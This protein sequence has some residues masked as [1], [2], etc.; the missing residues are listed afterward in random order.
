MTR[1]ELHGQNTG[2]TLSMDNLIMWALRFWVVLAFLK[3]IIRGFKNV[4]LVHF[5]GE[6]RSHQIETSMIILVILF[7]FWLLVGTSSV[8]ASIPFLLLTGIIWVI[9]SVIT[10][11]LIM[12]FLLRTPIS[13]ILYDYRIK[14]GRLGLIVLGTMLL[15]PLFWGYII[16]RLF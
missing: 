16:K 3:I 6:R 10:E 5:A 11:T 12:Y 1:K 15:A 4:F 13:L 7:L 14:E 2:R 8:E 9:L